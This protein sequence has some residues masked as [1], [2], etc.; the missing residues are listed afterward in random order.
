MTT[1]AITDIKELVGEMPG[2]VCEFEDVNGHRACDSQA[3]WVARCHSVVWS[4]LQCYITV[5]AI[6]EPH[7]QH[8]A[9]NAAMCA[10]SRCGSCLRVMSASDLFGPVMPL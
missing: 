4:T 7:R 1:Q 2:Q 5:I 10:N 3:R 8:I 9:A 6:C